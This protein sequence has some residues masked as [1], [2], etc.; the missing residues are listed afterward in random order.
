[1]VRNKEVLYHH[2]FSTLFY[3]EYANKKV[4][5]KR[6]D[7]N[8]KEEA[9]REI[10]LDVNI[11]KT[12]YV[13]VSRHQGAGQYQINWPNENVANLGITATNQNCIHKEIKSRLNSV[14]AR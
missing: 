6:K 7:W 13:V 11:E 8:W 3:S 12:K 2:W 1:M 4:Q 10:D 9:S 14:N 5:E